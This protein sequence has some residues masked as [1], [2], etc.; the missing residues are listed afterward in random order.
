MESS[1]PNVGV[2]LW[3]VPNGTRGGESGLLPIVVNMPREETLQPGDAPLW[4]AYL[5]DRASEHTRLALPGHKGSAGVLGD[6][7]AVDGPVW[8]TGDI[9]VPSLGSVAVAEKS[10]A[11]LWTA[12]MARFSVNG[13]S[14]VNQASIVAVAGDADEVVVSRSLH[15]SLLWGLVYS[16]ASPVWVRP[17]FD[18]FSGIPVGVS[19]ESVQAALSQHPRAMGVFVGDPS[20]AR[21]VGGVQAIAAV[22]NRAGVPLVVDAAWA[23]H[24]GFH[25]GLPSHALAAGADAM[26]ISVHKA[27]AGFTQSAM[28]LARGDRLDLDRLAAALDGTQTTSPSA[29]IVASVDAARALL[30][31]HGRP[32]LGVV[33]ESVGEVRQ[34]LTRVFPGVCLE[35]MRVDP[36][37]LPLFMPAVG[38]D[39]RMVAEHLYGDGFVLEMVSK[40]LL[41]PHFTLLDD[42]SEVRRFGA[43]VE[44]ALQQCAAVASAP[45]SVESAAGN[46]WQVDP[47]VELTP[48]EA[49]F[50]ARERVSVDAAVGRV[51]AELVCPY[52]P[53]VPAL[54]PGERITAEALEVV[55]QAQRGGV[56]IAY[57]SDPTLA[58]VLVVR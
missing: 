5:R 38:V 8:L 58:S 47:V 50:A 11:A 12:D 39:G 37:S 32:L 54:A 40:D 26:V 23:G 42:P 22:T 43:S 49:W 4:E 56:H 29:A 44:T 52:P 16:G 33:M 35:H 17:E 48:R 53:G 41:V 57:A 34:R 21:T 45:V 15:K 51:C 2:C 6:V 24:F 3:G 13:S 14:A 55:L 20:Y 36:M 7:A 27:L 28:L 19:A 10:A 1:P 46:A 31:R 30:A 25:E 9:R 18:P